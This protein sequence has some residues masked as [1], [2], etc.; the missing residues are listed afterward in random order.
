MIFGKNDPKMPWYGYVLANVIV[1]GI[2]ALVFVVTKSGIISS[3]TSEIERSGIG[4]F[5]I[6]IPVAF[7]IASLYDYWFDRLARLSDDEETSSES[8]GAE[9]DAPIPIA[10]DKIQELPK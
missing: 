9:S 10:A 5:L 3:V 4:S 2:T 7:L 8:S 6:F 1:W